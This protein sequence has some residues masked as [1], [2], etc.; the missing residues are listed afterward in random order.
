MAVEL[1]AILK[2]IPLL[3]VAVFFT[4]VF[5]ASGMVVT[6]LSL[7]LLFLWPVAP[8]TYRKITSGLAYTVLGRKSA[9]TSKFSCSCSVVRLILQP[10]IL[11]RSFGSAPTTLT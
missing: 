9:F 10:L 5:V 6:L 1:V 2:K 11:Q 3:L 8:T 4:Y 7:L